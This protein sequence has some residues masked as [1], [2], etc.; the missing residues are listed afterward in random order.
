M[1]NDIVISGIVRKTLTSIDRTVKALEETSTTLASGKKINSVLD[2]PQNFFTARALGNRA[3]DFDRILDGIGQSI[4]TIE[5]ALFGVEALEKLL[6][7]AE[8]VA[9]ES[10]RYLLAGEPDPA[11]TTEIVDTSS[12][13]ISTQIIADGADVYFRLND[14]GAIAADTGVAGASVTA[15]YGGGATTGAPALYSN[16]G[17][18]SVDFDGIN[19]IVFVADSPLINLTNNIPERTVEVVFNAD[20]TAGRQVI[21]EE[22]AG[23][24][25]MTI[26]IDNGTL[27]FTA[28]DDDGAVRYSN[29]FVSTPVVAGQTYYAAF[30]FD[31]AGDRFEGYLD[32]NSIGSVSVSSAPFPDHSGDTHIGGAGDAVQFHDGEGGSG[33]YFNGRI[34]DVAIY[35]NNLT[36]AQIL[37]HAQA[38]ESTSSARAVNRD[39][40]QVLESVD[41]L[42]IDA[43]YRGINLLADEDLTTIFNPERTSTLVTEGRDFSFNGLGINIRAFDSLTNVEAMIEEIRKAREEVRAFGRSLINDLTVISRRQDFTK[44][45]I[46]NHLAGADDL[47]LA[48]INEVGAQQLA[49]QVRLDIGYS[50]LAS[51]AQSPSLID[52]FNN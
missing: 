44:V 49:A 3:G 38:L 28:E 51:A 39:F 14:S 22:G 36:D 25:G 5:E 30:V 27:Y 32:G 46:N 34:S 12:S 8:A 1:V 41:E 52:L 15:T 23:V 26:Y 50:A 2:G 43:S 21:Y 40:E 11:V 42:I 48:D 13:P 19:D 35:N 31:A 4:R 10:R 17:T 29:I 6:D 37:S 7:Q 45:L 47:T 33:S 20:T 18:S 9:T 24:N 16:G